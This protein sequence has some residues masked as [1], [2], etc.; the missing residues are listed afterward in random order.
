MTT[1]SP[2]AMGLGPMHPADALDLRAHLAGEHA[3]RATF[4]RYALPDDG[5]PCDNE[6]AESLAC[7]ARD[8]AVSKVYARAATVTGA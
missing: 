2:D 6:H 1:L 8:V 4:A 3:Y 7:E 5:E